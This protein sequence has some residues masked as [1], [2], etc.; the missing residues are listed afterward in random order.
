[1]FV[2]IALLSVSVLVTCFLLI[3]CKGGESQQSGDGGWAVLIAQ[4]GLSFE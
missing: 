1:M 4:L 2:A 3:G